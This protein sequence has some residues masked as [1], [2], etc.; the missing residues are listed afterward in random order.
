M[1][2]RIYDNLEEHIQANKAL[3]IFGPR[4]VGKTTLLNNYLKNTNYK[5]KLD[6]GDNIRLQNTLKSQDFK[7][8]LGYAE[9]YELIAID[10]AQQIP[11]IGMALKILI[12]NIPNI[13]IIATGSSSFDLSQQIGEPLTGRK[14]TITLYPLS[15]KEL[16]SKFN[17][18]ELKEKLKDFL[19]FG[20]YP[21]IVLAK[22]NKERIDFLEELVNSYLLKDILSLDKIKS[23]SI[24]LNLLK[25]LSFQVGNLVS[26]NEL[27]NTLKIDAKTVD[28]YLDLLEK[29]FIIVRLGGFS[30]NLRNE[31]NSKAKYYFLD[32]GVRNAVITQYSDLENRDDIGQLFENFIISERI[33]KCS[34]DKIYGSRYFWRNYEGKEI[35]LL[36]EREG[37][38]FAYE[39]KWSKTNSSAPKDFINNYEN[40]EYNTINK[41]NYLDFII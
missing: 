11:N 38:I 6:S 19:I 7:K 8:I 15:Q 25:L 31:I 16:L 23:S 12:D 9:G 1:I 2:K 22:N 29:S 35:D 20:S 33:K 13:K 36:E 30:R 34:Y 26:L 41:N 21:D 5:Y 18:Q 14:K 28:R 10:E 4:R 39:F 24:L 37:K 27:A 40:S 17:K 32:N 3:I